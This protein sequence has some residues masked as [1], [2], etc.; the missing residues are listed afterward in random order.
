MATAKIIRTDIEYHPNLGCTSRVTS[1][2]VQGNVDPANQKGC[3][4][5][6]RIDCRDML[7]KV[8]DATTDACFTDKDFTDT[9]AIKKSVM[10]D[11]NITVETSGKKDTLPWM[12]LQW[13][14]EGE[15]HY[16]SLLLDN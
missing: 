3:I 8:T 11:N 4:D 15:L 2:V 5:M 12:R 13:D 6:M 10:E 16:W 7:K 1:H 14:D 9:N